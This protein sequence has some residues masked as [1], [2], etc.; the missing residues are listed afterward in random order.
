MFDH[1]AVFVGPVNEDPFPFP[2]RTEILRESSFEEQPPGYH[3][4]RK[5]EVFDCQHFER[6]KGRPVVHVK[7]EGQTSQNYF[8]GGEHRY[9]TQYVLRSRITDDT[10]I[11]AGDQKRP[12]AH[13][14]DDQEKRSYN[15][16]IH[17][18]GIEIEEQSG[19]YQHG[20]KA[21]AEVCQKD[22]PPGC[23]GNIVESHKKYPFAAVKN[24]V[25]M[26]FKNRAL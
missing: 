16:P 10:G 2:G 4:E 21:Q 22:K 24:P 18:F 13:P 7:K 6:D 26:K 14:H 25:R 12:R 11:G 19:G 1:Q 3:Q 9:D 20:E 8:P 15:A 23:I 5:G 17:P